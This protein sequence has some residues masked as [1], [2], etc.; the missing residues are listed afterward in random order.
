MR[1]SL[2]ERGR[3][4]KLSTE[5]FIPSPLNESDLRSLLTQALDDAPGWKSQET[6]H[7]R[8]G[9]VDRGIDINDVIH[10]IR[11]AW[12]FERAPE[13][14]KSE[15]QWKYRLA[16]QSVDEEPLTIIVA[17]DTANRAFE[18]VTRWNK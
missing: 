10:G 6:F 12:S 9:H 1:S 7:A 5:G 17:V 13:F 8:F 14:N 16:A 15:W 18:V 3:V 4:D 11:G 2:L